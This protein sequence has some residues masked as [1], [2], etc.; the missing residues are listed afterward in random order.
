M[1]R[2]SPP[3]PRIIIMNMYLCM[4]VCVL[5][6]YAGS[7]RNDSFLALS[8]VAARSYQ[9]L[10]RSTCVFC[11]SHA[12]AYLVGKIF[13]SLLQ[14][15]RVSIRF[16]TNGAPVMG[17]AE[18]RGIRPLQTRKWCSRVTRVCPVAALCRRVI[19]IPR[20]CALETQRS[21]LFSGVT[22]A[23]HRFEK[24]DGTLVFL[25][26]L[27]FFFFFSFQFQRVIQGRC[28]RRVDTIMCASRV[29]PVVEFQIKARN[30]VS[31]Q[32][33]ANRTHNELLIDWKAREQHRNSS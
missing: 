15:A 25:S 32:L 31:C 19:T 22:F 6:H 11:C 10:P 5:C 9:L 28:T 3:P 1:S 30:I 23:Q 33:S 14:Y 29:V 17:T 8:R 13:L 7:R 16:R 20:P 18:R 2:L 4:C 27:L 12:I 26:L 24:L 21:R